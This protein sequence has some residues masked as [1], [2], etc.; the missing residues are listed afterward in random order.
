MELWRN[1]P[2]VSKKVL[3][4]QLRQLEEDGIIQRVEVYNFP[5]EVY[6]RLT[7]KAVKLG[8]VIDAL[9]D[10]GTDL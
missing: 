9:H 4:E 1:M 5:P 3:S 2:S 10:W 8:P 6:Y 7:E